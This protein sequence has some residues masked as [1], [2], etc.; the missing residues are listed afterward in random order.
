MAKPKKNELRAFIKDIPFE[1]YPKL[2]LKAAM[3]NKSFYDYLLLTYFEKENGEEILFDKAKK[4][5]EELCLKRYK[6]FSEELQT[7]N[8]ISALTKRINEFTKVCKNKK[9]EADLVLLA[10]EITCPD[11]SGLGTCFT[12]YDYKVA[13]LTKRLVTII[14]K[15]LHE[16][17]LIEYREEANIYLKMLHDNSRHIDMIFDMIEEIK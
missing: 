2:I 1:D 11:S 14:T 7:A 12:A 16:D 3:E 13:L 15:H 10:L 17:Y 9:L 4:E 6:G 5:M 8:L